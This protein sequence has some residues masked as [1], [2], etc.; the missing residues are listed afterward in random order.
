MCHYILYTISGLNGVGTFKSL[1]EIAKCCSNLVQ[2]S[3]ASIGV[4]GNAMALAAL[5]E[6]LKHCQNLK[7]LRYHS[8]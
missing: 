7:K 2:L 6:A 1:I 5:P 3:L 8:I 4:P